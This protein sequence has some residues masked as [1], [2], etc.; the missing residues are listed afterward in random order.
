MAEVRIMLFL[1][2]EL[3]GVP[4]PGATDTVLALRE[5][6]PGVTLSWR[7]FCKEK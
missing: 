4:A 2:P 3:R 1:C 5:A 6:V 7:S